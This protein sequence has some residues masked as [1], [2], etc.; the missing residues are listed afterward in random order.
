MII[1]K[2]T[3]GSVVQV[4][5]THHNGSVVCQPAIVLA[6]SVDA[7]NKQCYIDARLFGRGTTSGYFDDRRTH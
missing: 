7:V 2:P 5:A 4:F 6:V 1:Y 3:I